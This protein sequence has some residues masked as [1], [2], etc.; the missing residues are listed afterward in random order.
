MSL[1]RSAV[2]IWI[3]LACQVS[4]PQIKS[5]TVI[6]VMADQGEVTI[7]ADSR[8]T[9]NVTKNHSESSCK[10][11][12]L[13]DRFFFTFSGLV[14]PVSGEWSVYSIARDSWTKEKKNHSNAEELVRAVLER[15]NL[16]A[17]G[18]YADAALLRGHGTDPLLGQPVFG[19]TDSFGNI[20]VLAEEVT[21]NPAQLTD[22]Q[23]KVEISIENQQIVR[24]G[25]HVT[26]GRRDV[27][28]EYFGLRSER[29][30][31][32]ARE[33]RIENQSLTNPNDQHAALVRFLISQ[34]IK[35]DPHRNE[36]GPPVD[37]IQLRSFS[38]IFVRTLKPGCGK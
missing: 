16:R 23:R 35:L 15:W 34:A 27:V 8:A 19:A 12:P 33:F 21:F 2:F 20:F 13:G 31:T 10:I 30:R 24:P 7:G 22:T 25:N 11:L 18:L 28:E 1:L 9:A 32:A 4:F 37:I 36:L 26:L 6:L 38:G 14:G 5:G 3:L 17:K 29:A